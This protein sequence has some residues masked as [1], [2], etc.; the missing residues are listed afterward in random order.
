[1]RKGF[2][3]RGPWTVTSRA[4]RRVTESTPRE[5]S[6]ALSGVPQREQVEALARFPCAHLLQTIS[7]PY[8]PGLIPS[9]LWDLADTADVPSR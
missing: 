4:S 1:M 2:E 7:G 9:I 5:E 6:S 3:A 8:Q